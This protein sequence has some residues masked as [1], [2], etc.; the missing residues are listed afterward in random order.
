MLDWLER[1]RPRLVLVS[2]PCHLWSPLTNLQYKSSQD[3]RRLQKLR[4]KEMP[5]LELTEQVFATQIRHGDDA[6]GENPLASASFVTPPMKRVSDH[7]EVYAAV[8][9][10]CRFGIKHPVSGEP[11]RK[12]TLWFST[13]REICDELGQRC[14]NE[15]I[16]DTTSMHCVWAA[17]M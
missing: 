16:P 15:E 8:G 17:H 14:K 3:G 12:A 11:I 2:Y 10:G 13:S 5:F 7:P 6:V 4:A 1:V 9:H